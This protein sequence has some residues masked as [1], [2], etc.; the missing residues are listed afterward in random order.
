MYHFERGIFLSEELGKA[1]NLGDIYR[2]IFYDRQSSRQNIA[3]KLDLSLP[4]VANNLK[5]L[6]KQG[7]I[8]NA[9]TFK[10][11]G[12]RKATLLRCVPDARYAVGIDITRNHL[13]IVIINLDISIIGSHRIRRKFE[14]NDIYY[15]YMSEELENLLDQYQI[16]RDKLIG[17][18]ISL[19]VIVNADH[20]TISYAT[21]ITVAPEIY[22]RISQHLPYPFLLFND[23]NS[24]GQ[25]ES[26]AYHYDN[27]VVYLSLSNSV[28][29]ATV[30]GR[31]ISTG[32]NCR[33]S[34]FGHICIVPN[35]RRCYCGRYGCLDAYCSA[36]I[37]SDFESG[38]LK[39][40]F[41][42]L[43]TGKNLGYQQVFEDYLNHMVSAVNILRMCY[44]CDVILGGYVG[45]Y[46]G[47]YL[48]IIREKA[49][50]LNP[51]EHNSDYIRVC[52]YQTEASAVGAAIYYINEFVET[53]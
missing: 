12:G 43:K 6:N 20:K 7:L 38:D 48:D 8:Y 35:G 36:K 40:F 18:G 5:L 23:A 51:F 16:T 11:T 32:D 37:L 44:D 29:G 39:A 45:A 49:S 46:L 41:T 33:A 10:S 50:R 14:D 21:V 30:N 34:E 19:P 26:W 42:E 3:D 53:I 9:G 47:D 22:N 27:T 4:T 28:G 17:V 25:A 52:H 31:D 1:R 2:T 24:A 15:Q 13:S